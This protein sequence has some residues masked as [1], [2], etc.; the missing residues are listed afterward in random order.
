MCLCND[1]I[2]QRWCKGRKM[3]NFL[4]FSFGSLLNYD[5]FL[6]HPHPALLS[7]QPSFPLYP[8]L[9][10]ML[11]LIVSWLSSLRKLWS[12]CH[13]WKI[14]EHKYFVYYGIMIMINRVLALP[15]RR[16]GGNTGV[17]ELGDGWF[18]VLG[19][20]FRLNKNPGSEAACLNALGRGKR[21]A[22]PWHSC[23][24]K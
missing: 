14:K 20:V 9:N 15:D 19:H 4:K 2:L 18:H 22:G 8:V 5:F 13:S 7:G 10:P 16:L 21:R 3:K 6:P 17:T 24:A 23:Q 11:T 1:L 12:T